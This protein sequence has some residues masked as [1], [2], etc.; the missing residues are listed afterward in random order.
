MKTKSSLRQIAPYQQGKQIQDIKRQYQ[1]D[2]IVKLSSNENPYGYADAVRQFL[3]S[4][5]PAFDI[6]PDGHTAQLRKDLAYKLKVSESEIIFGSGSEEI[7]QMI[8]RAYLFQGVNTVMA[9]P[10]FPQY[11]HNAII[12]G[13]KIKEIPTI[14]GHHDLNGMLEAIDQDTNV[15]WLCSPN[16]PTGTPITKQDFIAFMDTCP[17]HV[18]VVLDEAYYE[19]LD[20][21]KDLHAMEQIQKYNNLIIL[22]TFSKAYGLAG[23]RIGYGV[24]N[25]QIINQ[26]NVVRGPFN[27]T[28]I[29]QQIAQIALANE[30]FIEKT[31]QQNVKVKLDFQVFLDNI[32]WHYYTSETNFL[33]VSTPTSGTKVFDY[34]IQH[35]FIVRPGELLGIPN[36]IRFTLGLQ[37]DMYRMQELLSL[38]QH[39]NS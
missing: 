12:E 39:Q 16:N 18:L 7:V 11:K 33:L 19:Y 5:E 38:Y 34:L 9:T 2:R 26:L 22:R 10:T 32:G 6:Y 31:R 30:A 36:T 20:K 37:D 25:K 17:Q 8:C 28:S 35:G 27:T 24:A 29:A 3:A 23:L 21:T 4:Y 15:I 14:E 13:A 1:I